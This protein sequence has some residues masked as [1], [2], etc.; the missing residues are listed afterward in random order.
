MKLIAVDITGLL[1]GI[2]WALS[3]DGSAL[4]LYASGDFT[5]KVGSATSHWMATD[6]MEVIS[7]G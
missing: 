5:S 2:W 3:R 7:A 6:R 1:H 4:W